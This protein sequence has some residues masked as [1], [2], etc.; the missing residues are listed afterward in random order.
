MVSD[1]VHSDMPWFKPHPEQIVLRITEVEI[2]KITNTS[3]YP[4]GCKALGEIV[5]AESNLPHIKVTDAVIGIPWRCK[6]A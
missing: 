5:R 3:I 1:L 2:T 4:G 6:G